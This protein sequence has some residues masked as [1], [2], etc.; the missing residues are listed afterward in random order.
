MFHRV[1]PHLF[2]NRKNLFCRIFFS[3]KQMACTVTVR[4]AELFDGRSANSGSQDTFEPVFCF[5][6]DG[7]L[8][9]GFFHQVVNM[10]FGF[11]VPLAVKADVP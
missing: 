2:K 1:H 9:N 10:P 5:C 6:T 7:F 11:A 8:K 4:T 3:V